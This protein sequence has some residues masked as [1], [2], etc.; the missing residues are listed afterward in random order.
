MIDSTY[1]T[2]TL[3][4]TSA[5]RTSPLPFTIPV[6]VSSIALLSDVHS[7]LPALEAVLQDVKRSGAGSVVFLGDIV[8]YG[9][10]PAACVDWVRKLGGACLMGNHDAAIAQIRKRGSRLKDPD[11][12]SCGYQM[13]LAHSARALDDEQ[14]EWI[15]QLPYFM[16]IPGAVA[17][18]GSLDDPHLFNYI[19]NLA[20]AKPTLELLAGHEHGI[21]FFGHTHVPDVFSR[22]SRLLEWFDASRVHIPAGITC[23]VT[24]GSVGQPRHETDRRASWVLWDPKERVVEFRKVSYNRLQAAQDIVNARLPIDSAMRLLMDEEAAFLVR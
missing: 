23:A 15:S 16:E 19:F 9:A 24:V 13:G 22:E 2:Y 5:F 10:S 11:W 14:A 3:T 1:L 17:A 4:R 12:N 18:H 6:I 21:G 8:G 20:S 7:N